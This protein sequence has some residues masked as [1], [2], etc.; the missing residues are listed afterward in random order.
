[1][2]FF[3]MHFL[4]TKYCSFL[5]FCSVADLCALCHKH[6]NHL[7]FYM[8]AFYILDTRII[9][10]TSDF[11]LSFNARE[12]E[13]KSEIFFSKCVWKQTMLFSFLCSYL[14][15]LKLPFINLFLISRPCLNKLQVTDIHQHFQVTDIHQHFQK[16][17]K[18]F[19]EFIKKTRYVAD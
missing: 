3:S 13:N 19:T 14:I 17:F 10:S 12:S 18:I 1:M 2:V 9:T 11:Q 7:C 5:L 15:E 4:S 8:I 6:V 16:H